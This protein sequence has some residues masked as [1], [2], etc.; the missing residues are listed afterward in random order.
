MA[1]PNSN[2]VSVGKPHGEGGAYAG[3]FWYG[4]SGTA[5]VPTD[6]TTALGDGFTNGGYLADDGVTN[7]RDRDTT[8]VTAFG[9]DTVLNATASV[10]ETFAFGM[11][12]TTKDTMS[13]IYGPDNVS[14]DDDNFTV[15][16]NAKDAPRLVDVFEFA[17]TGDRVKRIVIPEGQV[18]DLDDVEYTDGDAVKYSPT[19]TAYPDSAGNTAYEYIA[20]VV[21]GSTQYALDAGVKVYDDSN[22]PTVKD[23]AEAAKTADADTKA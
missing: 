12:E 5:T 7:S 17:M 18:T 16:H 1:T 11:I 22:V 20:K 8:T 13:F 21:S 9:G 3:G 23:A 10:T 15:K 19:I 4:T 6:A 14:G 2:N